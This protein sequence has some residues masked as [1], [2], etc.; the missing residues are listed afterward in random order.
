MPNFKSPPCDKTEEVFGTNYALW[1]SPDATQV[2]FLRSDET[3]VDIFYITTYGTA[4]Y[5]TQLPVKYPK[6]GF[7]NPTVELKIFNIAAGVTGSVSFDFGDQE[8][9]IVQLAWIDTT[10]LATRLTNRVQNLSQ[11]YTVNSATLNA[12]MVSQQSSSTGWIEYVRIASPPVFFCKTALIPC[13]LAV[14]ASADPG[15]PA[16]H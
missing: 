12:T 8:F 14:R 1:W 11:L 5:P 6:P 10:S 7:T 4:P 9:L 3:E 16:V 15:F 13:S 2:A